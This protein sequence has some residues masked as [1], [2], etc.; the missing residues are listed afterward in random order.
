MATPKKMARVIILDRLGH[1]ASSLPVFDMIGAWTD[2]QLAAEYAILKE[3][4][5][6]RIA[7][8]RQQLTTQEADLG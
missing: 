1:M 8:Q 2:E 7:Q 5:T 3:R 6:G 4:A